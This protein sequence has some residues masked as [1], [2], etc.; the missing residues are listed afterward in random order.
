M[1]KSIEPKINSSTCFAVAD[2]FT[3]QMIKYNLRISGFANNKELLDVLNEGDG[4]HYADPTGVMQ[5]S[6]DAVPFLISGLAKIM[7][8]RKAKITYTDDI[9][10]HLLEELSDVEE[11]VRSMRE[12]LDDKHGS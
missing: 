5:F 1:A 8:T 11:Y 12:T 7:N 4:V 3:L 10:K 9:K 6:I 2:I